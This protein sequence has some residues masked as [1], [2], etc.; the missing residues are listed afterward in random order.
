MLRMENEYHGETDELSYSE[1][2]SSGEETGSLLSARHVR[3]PS[4]R[5]LG[6]RSSSP[7][8][9]KQKVAFTS[10]ECREHMGFCFFVLFFFKK[11]AILS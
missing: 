10:I 1:D 11:R 3:S 4:K 2:E 8:Q 9:K 7:A 6:R 5:K